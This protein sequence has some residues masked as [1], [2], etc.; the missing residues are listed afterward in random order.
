VAN[1]FIRAMLLFLGIAV[2]PFCVATPVITAG[3]ATAN[4]GDTFTVAISVADA[5]DLRAFQFDL[6]Y[7][8]S[9]L[10]LLSFTDAGTDF[11]AAATAGGGSLTGV[12]GFS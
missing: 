4:A 5:S 12:T 6:S 11:E 3:S 2:T 7:D 9:I 8:S 10:S 1:T